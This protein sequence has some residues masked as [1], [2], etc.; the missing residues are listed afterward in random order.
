[1]RPDFFGVQILTSV[2]GNSVISKSKAKYIVAPLPPCRRQGFSSYSFLTSVLDGVSDQSFP[3][4]A[5]PTGKGPPFPIG[6]EREWSPELVW[7]QKL[8]EKIV[9]L[10]R[11]SNP[12]RPVCSQTLY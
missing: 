3:G 1:M 7:T 2:L 12:V 8:E 11:G 5:L 10:C 4:R 6:Y 9:C